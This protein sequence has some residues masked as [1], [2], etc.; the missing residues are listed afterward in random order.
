[1]H[2]GSYIGDSN[3]VIE[4]AA[5]PNQPLS[6]AACCERLGINPFP[7]ALALTYGMVEVVFT[8][9]GGVNQKLIG[10]DV[11][12]GKP[13]GTNVLLV[14]NLEEVALL[15]AHALEDWTMVAHAFEAWAAPD[16]SV[17]ARAH[18]DQYDSVAIMLNTSEFMAVRRTAGSTLPPQPSSGQN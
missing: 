17:P 8:K 9:T 6:D 2:R 1:M 15:C 18:R 3:W 12:D 5:Q 4:H 11:E 13:T 10:I 14:I 7:A 16:A